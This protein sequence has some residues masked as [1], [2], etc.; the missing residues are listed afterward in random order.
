MIISDP[1]KHLKFRIFLKIGIHGQSHISET[2]RF[3]PLKS[4]SPLY[5]PHQMGPL[6][7]RNFFFVEL[8]STQKKADYA[9]FQVGSDGLWVNPS[10][11]WS[12]HS[13]N[14]LFALVHFCFDG[15]L[16]FGPVWQKWP[17]LTFQP[18]IQAN[19]RAEWDDWMDKEG[20]QKKKLRSWKGSFW[21]GL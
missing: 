11:F 2:E 14:Q 17:P 18:P 9:T 8:F 3:N 15:R 6:Q 20:Q 5:K 13:H 16:R 4:N 1:G 19:V 10:W 12:T 7:E 21:W